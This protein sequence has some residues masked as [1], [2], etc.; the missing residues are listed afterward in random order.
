MGSCSQ[1][2]KIISAM[3]LGVAVGGAVGVL[4]AP[5]KGSR[6]RR[7]LL[8]QGQDLTDAM[9]DKF[10]DF[11]DNMKQEFDTI[12]DDAGEYIKKRTAKS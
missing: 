10:D 8:A 4:F 3:L 2:L 1:N 11:I 7:K 5:E 9:K 12:K 6:T